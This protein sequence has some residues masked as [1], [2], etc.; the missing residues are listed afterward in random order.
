MVLVGHS[1][2]QAAQKEHGLWRLATLLDFRLLFA[3][4]AVAYE[5]ARK[6]FQAVQGPR[7]GEIPEAFKATG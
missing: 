2:Q 7:N 3:V 5:A 1:R 6:E 4:G